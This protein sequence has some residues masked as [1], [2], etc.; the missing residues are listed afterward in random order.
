[1]IAF[2]PFSWQFAKH[3]F[4]LLFFVHSYWQPQASMFWDDLLPCSTSLSE[5]VQLSLT[6][7]DLLFQL[8]C[9]QMTH[10]YIS[11]RL[12]RLTQYE[13]SLLQHLIINQIKSLVLSHHHSTCALVSEILESVLQTVQKQ[14]TLR[15]YILTNLNRRQYAEYTYIYSGHT[16]YY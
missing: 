5:N 9:F 15:Q 1:M 14:F 7:N 4:E 2:V 8:Q 13:V 10:A 16:V 6:G 12:S 11:R 3:R